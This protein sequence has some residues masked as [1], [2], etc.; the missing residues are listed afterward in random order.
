MLSINMEI[1]EPEVTEDEACA[2]LDRL[3]DELRKFVE[4]VKARPK[5]KRPKP[6]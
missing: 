4:H 6:Q 5:L 1:G 2:L 3:T